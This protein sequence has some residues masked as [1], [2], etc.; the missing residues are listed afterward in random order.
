M[1]WGE[2]RWDLI[3]NSVWGGNV[4]CYGALVLHAWHTNTQTDRETDTPTHTHTR[5]MCAALWL[6]TQPCHLSCCDATQCMAYLGLGEGRNTERAWRVGC[7][8]RVSPSTGHGSGYRVLC[9]FPEF[10]FKFWFKMSHF[11]SK[12]IAF[13]QRGHR[14]VPPKYATGATRELCIMPHATW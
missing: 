2:M 6:F 9:P 11:C 5:V 7:R 8:E 14:L 13:R 3:M 10:F 12:F 1:R 4:A